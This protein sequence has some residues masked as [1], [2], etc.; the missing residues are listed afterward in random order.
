MNNEDNSAFHLKHVLSALKTVVPFNAPESVEETR[1]IARHLAEV[2][3]DAVAYTSRPWKATRIEAS[4]LRAVDELLSVYNETFTNMS[5]R[6]CVNSEKDIVKSLRTVGQ[7]MIQDKKLHFSLIATYYAFAGVFA[8]RCK[9]NGK[10][11]YVPLIKK[12][13]CAFAE[14]EFCDWLDENGGWKQFVEFFE[15]PEVERK[16]LLKGGMLLS[17]ASLVTMAVYRVLKS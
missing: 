7:T 10:E 8:K 14:E 5:D 12:T 1:N 13:L 2:V 17:A 4:I 15:D 3:V 11:S 6:V 9:E 16:A